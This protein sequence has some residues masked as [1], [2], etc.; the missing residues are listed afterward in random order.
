[1]AVDSARIAAAVAQLLEAIGD[2]PEREG[3]RETPR[4]VAESYAEFFSGVGVDPL[5]HLAE[6]LP[7]DDSPSETV[8]VR[9]IRFRS[10]CEHHLLPFVGVAHIAYAPRERLI[11]LG[12]L[13]LVVDTLASRLQLQERL[14]DEI[15]DTI[16]RALEPLGVLVVLDATHQC[17]TTRGAR[18]E[19]SSTVTTASRGLLA[20]PVARTEIMT[21]IGAPRG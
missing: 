1:M 2:D 20:D 14:S 13:P 8:L 4:R 7:L 15:A 9:D 3:V 21:L 16:D 18:Q 17:V 10:M 12:R 6:T 19:L 5:E 11:G